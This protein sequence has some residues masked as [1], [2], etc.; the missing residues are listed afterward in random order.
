[1]I[2]TLTVD[3]K[4]QALGTRNRIKES[5]YQVCVSGSFI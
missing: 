3:D 4:G 1:M 5:F 2:V